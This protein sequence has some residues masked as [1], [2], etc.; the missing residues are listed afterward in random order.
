V[1]LALQ[2]PAAIAAGESNPNGANLRTAALADLNRC[3]S[4]RQQQPCLAASESLQ[5]LIRQ[6]EGAKQRQL[7]PRCLGALSHVETVLAAFLWQLERSDNLQRVI[8]AATD[9]CPDHSA[10]ISQ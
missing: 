1:V 6:E 9:Q 4:T 3:S 10:A 2:L 5:A 8:D 7:R